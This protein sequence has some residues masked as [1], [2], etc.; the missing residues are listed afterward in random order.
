M[1]DAYVLTKSTICSLGN[2][3]RM[4]LGVSQEPP[5]LDFARLGEPLVCPPDSHSIPS[6]SLRYPERAKELFEKAEATAKAKYERLV[7]FVDFYS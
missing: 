3:L 5:K 1:I 2:I 7:K 4:H 6:G